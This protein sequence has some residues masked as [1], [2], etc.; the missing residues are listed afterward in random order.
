[1]KLRH[2]EEMHISFKQKQIEKTQIYA[3]KCFQSLHLLFISNND[4]V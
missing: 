1:M 2:I 3:K 4:E